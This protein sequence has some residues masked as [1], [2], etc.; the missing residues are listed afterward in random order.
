[1]LDEYRLC[2]GARDHLKDLLEENEEN[3]EEKHYS[4]WEIEDAWMASLKHLA[5][6]EKLDLLG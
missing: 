3:E 4:F 2:N 1:M 5:F 6:F